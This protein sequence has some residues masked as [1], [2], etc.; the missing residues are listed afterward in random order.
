[1][2]FFAET[3]ARLTA[4]QEL[5]NAMEQ[6]IQPI[7]LTGVAQVH[8]AHL[9]AA[10]C[11]IHAPLLAVTAEEAEARRLCDDINTMLD[12]TAAWQFPSRELVLTPVEGV[13]VSYEHARIAALTAMRQGQCRVIIASIEA[14]LQPTIAPEALEEH[15]LVLHCGEQIERDA[16]IQKLIFGG[17]VRSESVSG[18]GQFSVR[19]DILDIFPVQCTAPIRLELWG[20]EIDTLT[21]FDPETQRRTQA[22]EELRI[23]PARETLFQP[24]PRPFPAWKIRRS[25][26]EKAL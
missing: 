16:L 24:D 12:Q 3:F 22:V 11:S 17:Y 9:L 5:C 8:K 1:M 2:Q 13:T 21:Q 26:K 25:G 23:P 7:S 14:L 15:T 19:G 18:A 6:G 4:Y 10:L 20:D